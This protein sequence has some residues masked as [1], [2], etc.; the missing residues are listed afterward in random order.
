MMKCTALAVIGASLLSS[1]FVNADASLRGKTL[2]SQR[3]RELFFGSDFSW[4]NLL[5]KFMLTFEKRMKRFRLSYLSRIQSNF[6]FAI[7]Q[8]SILNAGSLP[9]GLVF[10]HLQDMA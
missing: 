8:P 1:S 6:R 4:A 3:H 10:P 5:C 9:R 7:R 2:E